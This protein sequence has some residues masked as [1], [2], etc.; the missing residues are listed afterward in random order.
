MTWKYPVLLWLPA[1]VIAG[2]ILYAAVLRRWPARVAVRFPARPLSEA[3]KAAHRSRRHV[4]GVALASGALCA[5]LAAA[6]PIVSIPAPTGTPVA[7]IIDISRSMEETDIAPTRIEAAKSAAIEFAGRLPRPSRI[8]LV[9]F[10]NNPVLVVPLT[11]DRARVIEGVRNLTT[12][13]RTQ[14]GPGLV[15][16]V[17]AVT[18][19]GPLPP[20]GG[21]PGV[22]S[23]FRAVAVLLSDGRASD[24]IPPEEA[25]REAR[26]RGVRVYTVGLGTAADPST[27]RS[28]YW[29][30][31]DEPTLRMIADVTG[32]RYYK[33]EEAQQL[34]DIYRGLAKVI[35][36]SSRPTDVSALLGGVGLV[37]LTI[38]I[39]LRFRHTP[40][41]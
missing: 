1:L 35:G 25:A 2:T 5:L 18:G 14:L 17:R 4:A 19:E 3:S 37:L 13:L 10:G 16:G 26:T 31:L 36:W 39:V 38:A 34:R 22:A 15:E 9:T 11:D 40:I 12:Q 23:E 32:G 7:L 8:A 33:A 41:G 6:A 27:F 29:G 24:G 21:G 30:V 20:M 28:G